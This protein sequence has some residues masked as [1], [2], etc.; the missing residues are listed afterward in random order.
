MAEGCRNRSD[1]DRRYCVFYL[2]IIGY[3]YS[4]NL[5]HL[6]GKEAHYMYQAVYN[7]KLSGNGEFTKRCQH[8]FRKNMV[9]ENACLPQVAPRRSKW[10]P[11]CAASSQVTKSLFRATL[12]CRRR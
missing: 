12:S 4:F 9:S 11:S 7:G 2:I 8:Y 6:I 5:S 1:Y 3:A 10:R